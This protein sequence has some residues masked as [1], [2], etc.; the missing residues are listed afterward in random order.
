MD[1]AEDSLKSIRGMVI[2]TPTGSHAALG[3]WA[4]ERRIRVFIEKPLTLSVMA[5]E[6][7]RQ[8]AEAGKVPA[9]VGFVMRQVVSF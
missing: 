2:A 3:R 6:Q 5:S 7:L 8:S 1:K 4:I 9:Q